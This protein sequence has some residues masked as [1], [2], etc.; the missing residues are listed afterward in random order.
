[1]FLSFCADIKLFISTKAGVGTLIY[2][3]YLGF[4]QLTFFNCVVFKNV[5]KVE[6]FSLQLLLSHTGIK[7]LSRF[8][9]K[10][11]RKGKLNKMASKHNQFLKKCG[12]Q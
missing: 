2:M 5:L 11:S 1:V 12:T 3:H 7:Q 8:D 4:H 9:Q 10:A 6:V